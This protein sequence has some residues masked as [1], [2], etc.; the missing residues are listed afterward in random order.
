M[1]GGLAQRLC[2]REAAGIAA[3]E[4]IAPAPWQEL[5]DPELLAVFRALRREAAAA[6]RTGKRRSRAR[7]ARMALERVAITGGPRSRA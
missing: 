2:A 7:L 5:G 1:A 3:V 4:A 6:G